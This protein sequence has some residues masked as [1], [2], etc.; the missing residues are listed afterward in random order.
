M[1][2][3]VTNPDVYLNENKKRWG[4]NLM[5]KHF[6]DECMFITSFFIGIV[7]YMLQYNTAAEIMIMFTIAVIVGQS[8]RGERTARELYQY[9]I[10]VG[11]PA[12]TMLLVYFRYPSLRVLLT[13]VCLCGSLIIA[14]Y[15]NRKSI[16]RISLFKIGRENIGFLILLIAFVIVALVNLGRIPVLDA[17]CYYSWGGLSNLAN[18]NDYSINR[19]LLC[20]HLSIGYS[21]IA[22]IGELLFPHQLVGVQ[23]IN[24]LLAGVSFCGIYHVL[25]EMAPTKSRVWIV[26]PV[27]LFNPMTLG[28]IWETN[29]DNPGIYLLFLMIFAFLAN[30]FP[31]FYLFSFLFV[32]TKEPNVVYYFFFLIGAYY[33]VAKCH[34]KGIVQGIII[35]WKEVTISCLP[36]V[37]WLISYYSPSYQLR[38]AFANMGGDD[39]Q[40]IGF[41]AEYI[42]TRIAQFFVENFQWAE[43]V[44]LIMVIISINKKITIDSRI[45]LIIAVMIS[46]VFFNLAYVNYTH[47]RY[48][49]MWYALIALLGSALVL[50]LDRIW[51]YTLTA[52]ISVLM[53]L[54]TFYTVDPV[55]YYVFQQYE[56]GTDSKLLCTGSVFS[57]SNTS[58]IGDSVIYNMD[59]YRYFEQIEDILDH[60]SYDEDTVVYY[61]DLSHGPDVYGAPNGFF[62]YDTKKKKFLTY[63]ANTAIPLVW[64]ESVDTMEKYNRVILI[65]PY[66]KAENEELLKCLSNYNEV[67]TDVFDDYIFID[68]TLYER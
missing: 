55:S 68:A 7:L 31:L 28:M 46:V 57:N 66:L 13:S 1:L 38:D 62:Y 59:Y 53:C 50:F 18:F 51:A 4:Y 20:G 39:I 33:Y 19:F 56:T 27:I 14:L 52:I 37:A 22:L 44:V 24:I 29:I 60:Y 8:F 49:C 43:L 61:S 21:F 26:M 36:M 63:C 65:K 15:I 2:L 5:L 10:I 32:F 11:I 40:T 23:L 42:K 16:R 9:L 67:R 6:F 12:I 48:I 58:I 34:G 35:K 47:T 25:G 30:L 64:G 45:Y 41:N 3:R 54:Q 17:G